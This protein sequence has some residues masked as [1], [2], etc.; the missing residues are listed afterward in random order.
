[1]DQPC[2]DSIVESVVALLRKRSEV[3]TEKYGVTLDR[4]DLTLGDWL[5]HSVLEGLDDTLYKMKA[6]R[7]VRERE[8]EQ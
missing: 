8:A 4:D 7:T 6:L 5:E 2:N 1:M 3:G